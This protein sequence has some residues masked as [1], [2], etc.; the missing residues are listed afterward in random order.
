MELITRGNMDGLACAVLLSSIQ[1]IDSIRFAHPKDIQD[2]IYPVTQNDI[3]TNLPF[4][5]SCGMWFSNH[6]IPEEK[7]KEYEGVKGCFGK[8]TS[9]ARLIFDH[10]NDSRFDI[11]RP[12]IDAVDCFNT[13]CLT[14]EDVSS[15]QGWIAI[16]FTIDPRTGLKRFREYFVDMVE[17][18]STMTLEEILEVPEVASRIKSMH[19][20]RE[21]MCALIREN[22]TFN[23][24]V[25]VTDFR[26]LPENP[27]GNRFLV[28]TQYPE[29]TVEVRVFYGKGEATVVVAVGKSIFNPNCKLHVGELLS[30]YGGGGHRKAGTCQ[31]P[32]SDADRVISEI[33]EKLNSASLP[34]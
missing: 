5:P 28:F 26:D 20:E 9:T 16:G 24:H 15:P 29:A 4:H 33:V 27:V 34:R 21:K 30:A 1:S 17:W 32:S 3:L 31:I 18:I 14:E 19:E 2:G 11:H 23:K 6:G 8:A 22:A 13:A 25:V 7:R 10:Y 12:F